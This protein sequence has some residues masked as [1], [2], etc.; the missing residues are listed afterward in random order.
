[1]INRLLI[2]GL[3]AAACPVSVWAEASCKFTDA[4]IASVRMPEQFRADYLRTLES[5]CEIGR[6]QPL[7]I[8]IGLAVLRDI[9][10]LELRPRGQIEEWAEPLRQLHGNNEGYRQLR[11]RLDRIRGMVR[12]GPASDEEEIR[13]GSVGRRL[14]QLAVSG[15]ITQRE[16]DS[17]V[18]RLQG[19]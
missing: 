1:M 2:A 13:H 11:E 8:E 6:L 15:R 19:N 16:Y 7:L 5:Q 17:L 12:P 4:D 14:I 3:L 18:R 9:K 10:D